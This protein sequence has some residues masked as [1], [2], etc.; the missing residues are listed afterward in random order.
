MDLEAWQE[1]FRG[2]EGFFQA[3]ELKDPAKAE[4][5]KARP[6]F[7]FLTQEEKRNSQEIGKPEEKRSTSSYLTQEELGDDREESP[8]LKNQGR[9]LWNPQKSG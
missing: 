5:K 9:T 6:R 3:E 7:S 8:D 1:Y 4:K 2:Q